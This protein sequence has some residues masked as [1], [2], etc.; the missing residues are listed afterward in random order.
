MA[1]DRRRSGATRRSPAPVRTRAVRVLMVAGVVALAVL[2]AAIPKKGAGAGLG[3]QT[4]P[5][6]WAPEYAH[7]ARRLGALHLPGESDAAFHI[8]VRLRIFVD[9]QPVPVPAGIGIE[10][11]GGLLASL[12]THDTS[13]I[14]H[15]EADRPFPFTL[16]QFFSVWGVRFSR[17]HLG[18]YGAPRVY[19]DGRLVRD[20]AAYVLRAHD[21]IVVGIG[22]PGSF[23]TRDVQPF[24][25][26]L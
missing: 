5:A 14:V 21:R 25:P 11:A 17:A 2:V 9:G 18:G 23:P 26:G 3:L 19:V 1:A 20:P 7:L 10:P 12:H 24:P 8:H 22:R 16:G 13:G 15:I 4:G 6:P